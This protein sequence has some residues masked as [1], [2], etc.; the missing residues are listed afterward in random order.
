M[1][2]WGDKGRGRLGSKDAGTRRRGDTEPRGRGDV[3]QERVAG[4]VFRSALA[5]R[6]PP[7]PLG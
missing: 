2:R 6:Y 5:F 7:F 3:I 4:S 1:G